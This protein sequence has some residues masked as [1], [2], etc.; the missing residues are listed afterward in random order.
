MLCRRG[1]AATEQFEPPETRLAVPK[2]KSSNLI[3]RNHKS[4]DIVVHGDE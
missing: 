1:S 4:R 2:G 3:P